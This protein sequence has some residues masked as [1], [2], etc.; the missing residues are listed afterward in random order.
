MQLAAQVEN[1]RTPG[2]GN[3]TIWR[4]ISWANPLSSPGLIDGKVVRLQDV[5]GEQNPYGMLLGNG[6][7]ADSKNNV[8]TTLRM[9]YDL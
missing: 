1:V 5:L 3:S 4:E 8:N 9:D 6:Y 7:D 2:S